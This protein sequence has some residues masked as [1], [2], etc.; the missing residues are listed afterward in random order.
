MGPAFSKGPIRAFIAASFAT[1]GASVYV[2]VMGVIYTLG[3]PSPLTLS[4]PEMGSSIFHL[5]FGENL[6]T[7][8]RTLLPAGR[9]IKQKKPEDEEVEA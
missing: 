6:L 2:P 9:E 1:S 4:T 5:A 7:H 3:A 8:A